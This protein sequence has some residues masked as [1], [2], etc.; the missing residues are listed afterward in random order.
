MTIYF[1][2]YK[3]KNNFRQQKV[4]PTAHDRVE[5]PCERCT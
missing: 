2:I 3:N 5:W 1:I 4:C